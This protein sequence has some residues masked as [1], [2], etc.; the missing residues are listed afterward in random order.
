MIATIP[1]PVASQQSRGVTI[2][3]HLHRADSDDTI[4]AGSSVVSS[5]GLCPPLESC[6]NRNLFQQ[7]FGIE[8]I[9]DSQTHVRAISTY[10]FARCFGLVESIQY[11]LSHKRHKFGLDA[12]ML[13]RTLAWLFEQIHSHLVYLGD[14]NSEVFSPNQFAAQA[15]TIQTLISGAICTRLPSKERWVQAYANDSELCAVRELA[16]NPSLINN[17]TLSKVNH[18]FRGPLRH[19]LI[20][21]EDDMLIFREPISGSDSYTRL[22]LVPRELY[23]I[24]F[25]AFHANLIGGHLNKL[26]N[27]LSQFLLCTKWID[28]CLFDCRDLHHSKVATGRREH[29]PDG[30]VSPFGNNP[31]R[32]M[33]G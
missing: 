27:K 1:K 5:G 30:N 4:L 11:P 20:S 25:I 15:A 19:S 2:K 3:Y 24:L 28:D 33:S 6:P 21:V 12:S 9:H 14:A 8:F 17:Q 16:L 18:N 10:E 32:Q 7:F 26:L 29:L 23:N 31:A 22:T 13:G